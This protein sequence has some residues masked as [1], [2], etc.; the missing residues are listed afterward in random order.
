MSRTWLTRRNFHAESRPGN[1]QE[2]ERDRTE[3]VKREKT[4]T[5]TLDL[6]YKIHVEII[7]QWEYNIKTRLDSNSL[8]R[9]WQWTL[10]LSAEVH[11]APRSGDGRPGGRQR[12]RERERERERRGGEGHKTAGE[13]GHIDIPSE[14]KTCTMLTSFIYLKICID[15]SL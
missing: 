15:N 4:Y 11:A 6:I 5:N 10:G 2:G 8:D 1:G 12:E 7:Q 13:T 3:R 9:R 14:K